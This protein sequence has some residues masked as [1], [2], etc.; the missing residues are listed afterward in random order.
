LTFTFL[1]LSTFTFLLL[2][3]VLSPVETLVLFPDET[4]VLSP[5]DT[6]EPPLV[7]VFASLV[8][9]PAPFVPWLLVPVEGLVAAAFLD[10]DD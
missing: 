8:L 6:L 7:L 3:L 4:L 9:T 10:V 1:L 5:V 2:T